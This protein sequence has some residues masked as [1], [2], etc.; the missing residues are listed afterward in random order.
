M[1]NLNINHSVAHSVLP[2]S[3]NNTPT[4]TES[5]EVQAP[6]RYVGEGPALLKDQV[7]LQS[8]K[9]PLAMGM[10]GGAFAGSGLGSLAGSLTRMISPGAAM[11]NNVGALTGAI[12]G[13]VIANFAD[14]PKEAALYGAAAGAA[15]S[16]AANP[17]ATSNV[18]AAL[19]TI[20]S[21]AVT[22]AISAYTVNSIV[23]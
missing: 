17:K 6:G 3:A 7:D 2:V 15:I 9:L 18:G 23:K 22:G 5:S 1:A 19:L 12:A 8:Q 16:L 20:A 4:K 13:G 11:S 21:G 10:I 14:S